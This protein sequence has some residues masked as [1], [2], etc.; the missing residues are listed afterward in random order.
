MLDNNEIIQLANETSLDIN[1]TELEKISSMINRLID[2][3]EIIDSIDTQNVLPTKSISSS[4]YDDNTI[5]E[6]EL[7]L[8][9]NE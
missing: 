1:D 8:F 3:A 2:N 7:S 9:K 5:N 6:K 4:A